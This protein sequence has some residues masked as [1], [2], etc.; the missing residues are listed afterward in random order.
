MVKK[1]TDSHSEIVFS[2]ELPKDDPIKRKP[3]ISK[4]KSLLEWEPKVGL[5]EG[6]LKTIEYVKEI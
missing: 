4:A 6:L 2:E 3:D 5:E 1:L